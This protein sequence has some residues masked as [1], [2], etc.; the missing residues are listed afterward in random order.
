MGGALDLQEHRH[1]QVRGLSPLG[2]QGLEWLVGGD[3]GD[4]DL[5]L[6]AV[7]GDVRSHVGDHLVDALADLLVGG[8]VGRGDEG[9]DGV[10]HDQRRFGGVE[11][12]DRLAAP[13]AANLDDGRGG[14]LGE[15]VDVGA[16]ARAG[17]LGG[18]GGDDLG[19]LD[20]DDPADCG[21]HRDGGLATAGDHVGVGGVEVLLEVDRG[22]DVGADGGGG[23]V[24]QALAERLQL[25]GVVLVGLGR[26]GVE[27]DLDLVEVGQGH[28]T[29]DALVRG[30]EAEPLGVRQAVRHG[31]DADH[32]RH[33]EVLAGAHHLDHQVG[34]N[35]ARADDR[36]LRPG[37]EVAPSL[38]VTV[39]APSPVRVAVTT[40]PAA[41]GRIGP[42]APDRTTSPARSGWPSSTAVLASQTTSSTGSPRQAVPF[43]VETCR[44]SMVIDISTSTG[45]TSVRVSRLGPSTNTPAEAL[46]ATVSPKLMSQLSMRLPQ[47]SSAATT[48][49]VACRTCAASSGPLARSAPSTKAIS[50]SI[51]GCMTRS[52]GIVSPP[53]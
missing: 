45:S 38:R 43:P 14:G 30:G 35:V 23:E 7:A 15:L 37:H 11:D 12:D 1:L 9:E 42:R 28:Q 39:T 44:L 6:E 4:L 16:G 24:D 8:R 26:G 49:S 21:H 25:G 46:S 34:A 10:A 27:D 5:L 19:V 18:D 3:L 53:R 17:R 36:H 22:D 48:Y 32:G 13:G 33:L 29:F 20:R 47:T 41:T 40:L 2:E 52:A 51:R 31:I 50:A